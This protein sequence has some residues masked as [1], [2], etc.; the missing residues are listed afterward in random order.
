MLTGMHIHGGRV[1]QIDCGLPHLP[2]MKE[3]TI[4]LVN[5]TTVDMHAGQHESALTNLLT[6]VRLARLNEEPLLISQLVRVA[7]AQIAAIAT[8]ELLQYPD[9]N[10]AQLKRM[11]QAWQGWDANRV[12]LA[13][14]NMERAMSASTFAELRANPSKLTELSGMM[15]TGSVGGS[16]PF[17]ELLWRNPEAGAKR[18]MQFGVT[19]G[20]VCWFSYADERRSL[21]MD[22]V[23]V[24]GVRQMAAT[25]SFAPAEA[26]MT[27]AIKPFENPSKTLLLAQISLGMPIKLHLRFATFET[28][29]RL[30][31]TAIALHRHRLKHGKFP[32]SLGALVPEF[33]AEVPRDFMDGQPL[34]YKLQPDGQFLLWS[35]GEDFKDD[36]GDPTPAGWSST[37]G[38]FSSDWFTLDWLKG[39]DW[40]WPQ[41]AT[42]AGVRLYHTQLETKRA[43]AAPKPAP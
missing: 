4:Y 36:G 17:F 42:E 6:S 32:E 7:C 39:R 8:W 23:L 10:D 31:F 43:L 38:V 41:A 19:L 33:L 15:S 21:E 3:A 14:F 37:S 35:V 13:A 22:Q 18:V 30:T 16:D 20:W 29:R 12:W 28:V 27:T 1:D 5:A 40:V 24:D 26:R 25:G 2:K 9:W 11:Q 34:R